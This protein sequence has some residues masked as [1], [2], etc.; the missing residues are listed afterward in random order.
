MSPV[1][2]NAVGVFIVAMMAVFL[3]IWVWAWLPYHKSTHGRLARLPMEDTTA[4][5]DH[6]IPHTD[7]EERR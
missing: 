3:A 4:A 5:T 1:W 7:Q 6:S 2:G